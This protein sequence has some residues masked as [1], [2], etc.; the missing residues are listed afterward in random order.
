MSKSRRLQ[1]R[2]EPGLEEKIHELARRW[3]PVVPLTPSQV[4]RTCVERAYHGAAPAESRYHRRGRPMNP[5]AL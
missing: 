2:I 1:V 4:I 3:G 5:P